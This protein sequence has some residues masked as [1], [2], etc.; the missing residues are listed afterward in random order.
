[1]N[2]SLTVELPPD[3]ERRIRAES[4]DFP[5]A[6]REGFLMNLFR[7]GILTHYELGQALG[8]DRFET[9]AALKRH[10]VTEQA[11]THEE[12][13]ADASSLEE[14]RFGRIQP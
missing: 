13:D 7:R 12:I 1:M 9:D 2:I 3:V 14:L 4:P 11:L 5:S 10:Q 6:V 8:L